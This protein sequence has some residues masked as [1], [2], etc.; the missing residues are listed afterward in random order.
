MENLQHKHTF[1]YHHS[2]MLFFIGICIV[3]FTGGCS[4]RYDL[5]VANKCS[6]PIQI[7]LH[8]FTSNSTYSQY[9]GQVNPNSINTF[10][11]VISK[12]QINDLIAVDNQNKK[13]KCFRGSNSLDPISITVESQ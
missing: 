2:V 13:L 6:F 8:G 4:L 5:K 10:K 9:I 3:L 1:K 7:S 11:R 12:G